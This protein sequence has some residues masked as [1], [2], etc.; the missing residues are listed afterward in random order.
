MDLQDMGE[1]VVRALKDEIGY[2][3]M[4]TLGC[5]KTPTRYKYT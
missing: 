3:D 5:E 2:G 1:E 4:A